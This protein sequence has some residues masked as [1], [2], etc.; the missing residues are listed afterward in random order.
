MIAI[1]FDIDWA[2]DTIVDE[3]ISLLNDYSVPATFFCTNFT[4]DHS[5]KS[6]SLNGRV[7]QQS[8]IALHPNFQHE[9]NYEKEWDEI[10]TIYPT[11]KGWRSHNGVSGWP[12]MKAAMERGLHYEVFSSVFSNYVEPSQV[13]RALPSYYVFTTAFW[14]SHMLHDLGFSWSLKDLPQ[15][16]L[17]KDSDKIFVMGFHPN[18]LYYDMRAI[19][20]YDARKF[21]YHIVDK[22]NSFKQR[23]KLF[24]AMKL[25]MEL[26]NTF[27]P[28][29]F[30]TLSDF[31]AKVKLWQN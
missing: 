21:S 2:P 18:I 26:L 11:A 4:K 29:Y 14:D 27:P 16:S 13:N 9:N 19:N 7:N 6:S 31:G 8:E 3:L 22:K 1:T 12:I 15:K 5:K 25:I 10:L 28:E 23:K 20:E 17:F 30:T 24:G